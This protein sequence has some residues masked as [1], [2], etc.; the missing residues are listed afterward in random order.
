MLISDFAACRS[1]H[2]L[3]LMLFLSETGLF[4]GTCAH[5]EGQ[6]SG[7]ISAFETIKTKLL[8]EDWI[9]NKALSH[10]FDDVRISRRGDGLLFRS[11]YAGINNFNS[12]SKGAVDAEKILQLVVYPE[13]AAVIKKMPV[14]KERIVSEIRRHRDAYGQPA[15]R[16]VQ[17]TVTHLFGLGDLYVESDNEML[18][19][20]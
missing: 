8:S 10:P 6:Y 5:P 12:L 18:S 2:D 9:D 17:K 7:I 14:L 4:G 19:P 16:R 1:T 15:A 11:L 13:V 3:L 20:C